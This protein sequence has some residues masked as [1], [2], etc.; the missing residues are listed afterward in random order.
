M[1]R[2]YSFMLTVLKKIEFRGMNCLNLYNLPKSSCFL[3]LLFDKKWDGKSIKTHV[4]AF[5][6]PP[7]ID[8]VPSALAALEMSMWV[9]HKKRAFKNYQSPF[10]PKFSSYT[11]SLACTLRN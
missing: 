9:R 2:Y 6:I 4:W 11:A 7:H 10:L 5:E 3:F 8:S 1:I